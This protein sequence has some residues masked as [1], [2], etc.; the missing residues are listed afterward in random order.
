M[1][2][3]LKRVTRFYR[4]NHPDYCLFQQHLEIWAVSSL[5]GRLSEWGWSQGVKGKQRR[6]TH[7]KSKEKTKK[8]EGG[9]YTNIFLDCQHASVTLSFITSNMGSVKKKLGKNGQADVKK[10][11]FDFWLLFMIIYDL[12]IILPK[13]Y[14]LTTKNSFGG[15]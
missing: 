11:Y 15:S 3:H 2:A 8:K 12:K 9:D 14:F 13:K 6:E 10:I 1:L 5:G 7:N 4:N